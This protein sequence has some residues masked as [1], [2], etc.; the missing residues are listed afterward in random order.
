MEAHLRVRMTRSHEINF[1]QPI[2]AILDGQID[3]IQMFQRVL[4]A[5]DPTSDFKNSDNFQARGNIKHTTGV[6]IRKIR[7]SEKT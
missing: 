2:E 3:H 1:D 5:I 6:L 7:K 4:D